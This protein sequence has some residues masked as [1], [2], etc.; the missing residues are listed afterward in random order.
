V[1]VAIDIFRLLPLRT[2]SYPAA[3]RLTKGG[4]KKEGGAIAQKTSDATAK[5]FR[6]QII[7][8]GKEGG[9]L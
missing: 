8:K 5:R 2:I 1:D 4:F 6:N 7:L 9:Y 3:L